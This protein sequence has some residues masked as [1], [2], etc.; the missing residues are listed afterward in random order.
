MLIAVQR[1]AGVAAVF[2]GHPRLVGLD[3]VAFEL[4]AAQGSGVGA[5]Q[6]GAELA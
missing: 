6:P 3:V 2:G 4:G 1:L 5:G